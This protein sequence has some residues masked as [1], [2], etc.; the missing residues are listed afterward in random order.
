MRRE[1][2]EEEEEERKVLYIA[3]FK[4]EVLALFAFFFLIGY[5]IATLVGMGDSSFKPYVD[6]KPTEINVPFILLTL[7]GIHIIVS[8]IAKRSRIK[9]TVY[10]TG[11]CIVY[12]FMFLVVLTA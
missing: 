10:F 11:A 8:S 5:S 4:N 3:R 1:E 12:M 2:R 9:W 6:Y 7:A